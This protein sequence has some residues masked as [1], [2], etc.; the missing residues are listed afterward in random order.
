MIKEKLIEYKANKFREKCGLSA[1]EPVDL[2]R[3]LSKLNV[4]SFFT[5]MSENFSGMAVKNE[6]GNFI[7]INCNDIIARQHFTIAHELYHLYIQEN[8]TDEL[9]YVGRFNKKDKEEYNADWFA[10]YLLMPEFAIFEQISKDELGKNKITIDTII[11]MEQYF[12]VSRLAL[13]NR[14]M[15][16]DLI[17]KDKK[18]KIL[19]QGNI[20]RSAMLLGF[21]EQQYE[22]GNKNRFIGDYGEKAKRLY[23]SELISETDYYSLMLEIGIDIDKKIDENAKAQG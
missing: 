16:I 5:A 19:E 8:F 13:L 18:D 4:I 6:L 2:Y 11:K 21:S 12:G 17:S 23:D 14:L 7:M 20:K 15:F 10:S 1:A 3:L 9:C 22:P